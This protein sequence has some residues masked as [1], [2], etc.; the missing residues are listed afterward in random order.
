ML[1]E[2]TEIVPVKAAQRTACL[3]GTFQALTGFRTIDER[4]LPLTKTEDVLALAEKKGR[5]KG[6]EKKKIKGIRW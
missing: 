4:N 1:T 3:N 6:K 2:R 5:R